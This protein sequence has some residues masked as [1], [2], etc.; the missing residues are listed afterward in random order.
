M[1]DPRVSFLHEHG[2]A[3]PMRSSRPSS[4]LAE[5]CASTL[6][7]HGGMT[8]SFRVAFLNCTCVPAALMVE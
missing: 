1:A 7:D 5:A 4:G 2:H 6:H 8:S 3:E